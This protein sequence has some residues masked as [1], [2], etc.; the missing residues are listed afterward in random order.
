M[1]FHVPG[2]LKP[3]QVADIRRQLDAASWID[4][5]ASAGQDAA[6]V[7]RNEELAKTDPASRALSEKVI[8]ALMASPRFVA[9]ALPMRVVPPMFSRYHPGQTYGVHA[10]GAVFQFAANGLP[11]YVRSDLAATLFLSAPEDY[12]GGELVVQDTFGTTN[13]KLPAGDVVLYPASSLHH[14][15]PVTRGVRH[16]SFFWVQSMVRSD[17]HRSQLESLDTA[18]REIRQTTPDS[19]AVMRLVALY[20]N[21]L[22]N[23]AET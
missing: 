13:V 5:R 18:I 6:A 10:D 12:D 2:V 17:E 22:R 7:K 4:G 1:L 3:D 11:L 15:A 20:H 9:L 23:W 21:L 19:P 14:V 8:A 16:V